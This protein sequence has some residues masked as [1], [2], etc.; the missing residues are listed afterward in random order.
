LVTSEAEYS[1]H[2]RRERHPAPPQPF[3]APLYDPPLP[4]TFPSF[5]N[6]IGQQIE[7]GISLIAARCS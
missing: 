6:E 7:N 4:R 2:I 3:Q 1:T 5:V